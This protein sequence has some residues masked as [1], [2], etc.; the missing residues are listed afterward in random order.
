MMEIN[1]DCSENDFCDLLSPIFFCD[2]RFPSVSSVVA[3][4]FDLIV[5]IFLIFPLFTPFL[6]VEG[7]CLGLPALPRFAFF[8]FC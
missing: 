1:P 7:F 8:G 2:L 5:L 3:F 4:A 6:C